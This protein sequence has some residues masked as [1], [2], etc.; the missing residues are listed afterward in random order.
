[1]FKDLTNRHWIVND[2]VVG[3]AECPN[4]AIEISGSRDDAVVVCLNR[5]GPYGTATYDI[6]TGRDR[7]KEKNGLYEIVRDGTRITFTT[8]TG[9]PVTGSWTANDSGHADGR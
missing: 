2:D 4:H 6:E 9:G 5:C 8:G 7:L 3:V 1:M